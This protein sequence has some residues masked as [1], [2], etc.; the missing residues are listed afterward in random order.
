MTPRAGFAP[1]L[2]HDRPFYARALRLRQL[3]PSGV[4]CFLLF[5]VMIVVGALL[6]LAELVPWWGIAAL[7]AAVAAMVKV[8]DVV[9]VTT[10]GS[11][12]RVGSRRDVAPV[13]T[14]RRAGARRAGRRGTIYGA[15]TAVPPG[16]R[17]PAD[18][19]APSGAG[20]AAVGRAALPAARR[21]QV[22]AA[23]DRWRDTSNAPASAKAADESTTLGLAHSLNALPAAETVDSPRQ[24]ARQSAARRYD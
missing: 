5:E 4:Q 1:P 13:S 24:R 9:A 14:G 11:S 8:N 19:R 12:S 2:A 23:T 17:L 20:R 18:E 10:A 22:G 21:G 3:Q 6:A 15:P 16:A 7:P